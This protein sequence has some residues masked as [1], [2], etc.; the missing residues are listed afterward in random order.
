[1]SAD[2]PNS[3]ESQEHFERSLNTFAERC[4]ERSVLRSRLSAIMG[5]RKLLDIENAYPHAYELML[6]TS[7]YPHSNEAHHHSE[8]RNN[9][10]VAPACRKR[11]RGGRTLW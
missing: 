11:K 3:L 2:N 7:T 4:E 5:E 6:N 8:W 9:R 10:I 1:M